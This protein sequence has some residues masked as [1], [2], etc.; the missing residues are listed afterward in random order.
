M[1]NNIHNGDI[2]TIFSALIVNDN[3]GSAVDISDSTTKEI[4]FKSPTDVVIRQLAE[5]T[6]DG[7]DGYIYYVTTAND[8][9]ENGEWEIQGFVQSGTH[10]NSSKIDTFIVRRNL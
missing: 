5:F 1:S 9:N 7:T 2:G 4:V 6:T 10:T 3:I 8:L